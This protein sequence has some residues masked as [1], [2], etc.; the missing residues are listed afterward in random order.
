MARLEKNNRKD[1]FLDSDIIIKIV[2]VFILLLL[3]VFF[4]SAETALSMSNKVRLKALMEAGDKRAKTALK[5]LDDY[6]SML[7]AILIGNNLVN[8]YASSIVT[9]LAMKLGL[10]TGLATLLL[11][12]MVLLFCEIIP[13]NISAIKSESL[14]LAFAGIIN[15]VMKILTPIIFLV[16]GFG[17]IFL[18]I[19]K[20]DA[21]E[22]ESMT[23]SELRTYVDESH[24]DGVIETDEKEMII[25]VFNF[26]DTVAK[27]VMIPRVDMVTLD[28]D[29]TLDEVREKF[30]ENMYT[31]FP[32]CEQGV[33]N[34][35]GFINIKDFIR[36]DDS[37]DFDLH[38][39]LRKPF[40]T[41]EYRKTA[42]LLSDMRKERVTLAFVLNE[43]GGCEGMVTIEDLLEEIVGEI[44][45][46]YDAD[47]EELIQKM[48]ENAY[49]IEGSMK[50]DDIND[51]L[52][53]EL[54]SEDYDSIGGLVIENLED[55]LPE[56]GD[57]IK[58][59]SGIEL[60]VQGMSQNRISKVLMILPENE[61]TDE[62]NDDAEQ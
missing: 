34:I 12:V 57:V 39:I 30:R 10:N 17:N 2:V 42:D 40:F 13:K 5:V 52:E 20:L 53:T 8:L 26:G 43:Y 47:E 38:K 4:S 62:E 54:T 51:A 41:L 35:I 22:H 31:R 61:D 32:V 16:N 9:A 25:N 27:D 19:I 18:K 59:P 3:S 33:D 29:S 44:R 14:A 21:S 28:E 49:L 7:S 15:F 48:S 60:R 11:T 46:E 24:K 45:D 36:F 55:R 37:E 58:L 6:S 50:L 23:E 56:D 1:I